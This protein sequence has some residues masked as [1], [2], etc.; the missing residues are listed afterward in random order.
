MSATDPTKFSR[1]EILTLAGILGVGAAVS[2]CAGPGSSS[3]QGPASKDLSGPITG[4][5]SF[6]HWRGEDRTVLEQIVR[7]FAAKH[8]GVQVSQEIMP[9]QDYQRIALQRVR[10]GSVGDLF[11]AFRGSQFNDM[12]KAGL[13]TDLTG[14]PVVERYQSSYL[15]TGR[16]ENAQLGLPYQLVFNMPLANMDLLDRAGATGQPDS[17]D[18]FLDLCDKLKTA[19]VDPIIF[20]GGS[21]ADGNQ[22]LNSMVMNNAP[23]DDMFAKIESGEYSCTD[24]WYLTTLGQYAELRPFLQANFTGTSAEAAQQLF[25]TGRGGIFITGS[26]YIALVR[27]LGAKFPIDLCPPITVAADKARHVGIHNT[28]FI[29]GVNTAS[30]NRA[31]AV[32][33]LEHLSDPA[34]AGVY[35]NGTAQHV[36]VAGVEYANADL[37][38]LQ[39]W[40]ERRTLIAPLFQFNNLNIRTAVQNAALDVLAGKQPAQAAEDAQRIVAQN[41]R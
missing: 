12:V 40:L 15:E 21:Q 6:A 10:N 11:T 41:I 17:W 27:G 1:R 9:S 33:L 39:P 13:F 34:V 35:A 22:L 37:K 14:L 30:D 26:Y 36:T 32:A 28:T 18:A 3:N 5:V 19:N 4:D 8:D 7:D 25:A 23:S 29:L 31:T 2:A 38:A 16:H 24:D 20:P